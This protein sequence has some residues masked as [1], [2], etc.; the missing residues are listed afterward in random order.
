MAHFP[1]RIGTL[2]PGHS[3]FF[4]VFILISEKYVHYL[5]SSDP[6]D[7]DRLEKLKSKG[8]KKLYIRAEEEKNY[9]SYMEAGLDSLKSAKMSKVQKGV[10]ARDS[11]VTEAENLERNLDSQEGY[12]KA[13]N[14]VSK[15]LEYLMSDK[16]AAKS[17]LTNAGVSTD[18]YQHSANVASLSLGLAPRVGIF[19]P[20]ELFDLAMAA[21]IHDLGKV[22][23]GIPFGLEKEKLPRNLITKYYSHP[24]VSVDMVADKKYVTAR[25]LRLIADHEEI[26]DGDGFPEHKKLIKLPPC[27]Q[28][29][30]LCNDYERYSSIQ[31]IPPL[32]L[33]RTYIGERGHFFMEEHL[34]K[35][36]AMLAGK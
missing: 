20:D 34:L 36:G 32:E 31:K 1:I 28:V 24:S 3:V 30:N 17:I 5:R 8:V 2:R 23:L 35:L 13:Q 15:V 19:D 4:D 10:I 22:K 29:L 16:G 12:E 6:F 33:F 25:T 7:A 11:M 26:G 18:A 27:S 9:L 14:R 21:L